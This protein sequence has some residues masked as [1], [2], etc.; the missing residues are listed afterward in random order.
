[1]EGLRS[2]NASDLRSHHLN[3]AVPLHI[4]GYRETA[5][6]TTN[7]DFHL[8]PED[9][10]RQMVIISSGFNKFHLA[11]A[12]AEAERRGLLSCFITGA[13]PTP[14][15]SSLTEF[16]RLNRSGRVRRFLNRGEDIAD[17][18]VRPLWLSEVVYQV[19]MTVRHIGRPRSFV[20][21]ETLQDISFRLYGRLA[22]KVIAS[23]GRAEIYH[24]RAG[25]GHKSVV[26][27]KQLGM[28]TLCDH[29]IAH[30]ATLNFLVTHGGALPP[31]GVQ[32][33]MNRMWRHILSDVDQADY[34]LVNS[35]F[36][37]ETFLHQGW[38]ANRLRVIYWGADDAFLD[39]V[40]LRSRG[41]AGSSTMRLLFAGGFELRKGAATVMAALKRCNDVNWTLEI[42]GTVDRDLPQRDD[43]L[44]D[45]RVTVAGW[46]P[47]VDLAKR[48]AAAEVLVFPSLA[49]GSA[50]VVFEALAAGCYVITT[51][52]AGSIV[53]DRIHGRLV[54]PNDPDRLA[55]ALRDAAED[56]RRVA[57]VGR[58][59]AEL[60][61][62]KYRQ[63]DYGDKL[64]AH[65]EELLESKRLDKVA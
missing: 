9:V 14:R 16:A 10:L 8:A 34:V 19:A 53:E 43:F 65:Y 12:A 46:I 15:V 28:I 13:Y 30:P 5:A 3:K 61:R 48:M 40:P 35:E 62:S 29:S 57:E 24:Y 52:N 7:V 33:P 6:A 54:P 23:S 59:N 20:A 45:P 36:V 18:K 58:R 21:D 22:T 41:Q 60:I 63:C 2:K 25:F 27:A 55:A 47:R 44:Q 49:E 32:G 39:A 51:P 37:R 17:F 26:R 31:P 4:P 38:N 42:A 50:R 11:V 56:R 64:A 1:M